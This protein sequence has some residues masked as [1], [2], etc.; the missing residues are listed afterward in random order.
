MFQGSFKVPSYYSSFVCKGKD[1]RNCCCDGWTITLTE[2]EYFEIQNLDVSEDLKEKIEAYVGILPHPTEEEYARIN[3]N[4][5]G[6]CPLRREDNGYC[7]LQVEVGEE[8]IPSICRY[9]PR[10][11]RLYPEKECCISNSCEWVIEYLLQDEE[12]ISFEKKKLSFAFDDDEAR[13]EYAADYKEKQK[14][15]FSIL[16]DRS[17]DVL[18]RIHKIGSYLKV[19]L[20][21]TEYIS[22]ELSELRKSFSHSASLEDKLSAFEADRDPQVREEEIHRLVPSFDI[23]AE[24]ILVNHLFFLQFPYVEGKNDFQRAYLGLLFVY[25]FGTEYI[26]ANLKEYSL[27]AFVDLTSVYFR[28]AEHSN[29]YDLASSIGRRLILGLESK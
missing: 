26:L 1:C 4:Y 27:E 25:L 9:Y 22:E 17:T 7:G 5:R 29:F 16:E 24:K 21:P 15:C 11:P 18:S 6:E 19:P 20:F 10:A 13:K 14:A 3:L 12:K 2:K 8:K 28:V 23:K